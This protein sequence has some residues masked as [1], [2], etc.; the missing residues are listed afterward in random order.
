MFALAK[1]V[2]INIVFLCLWCISFAFMLCLVYFI[3][4]V[5]VQMY[6]QC[7]SMQLPS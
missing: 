6:V 7:S 1:K 3:V 4:D 2:Q 5:C